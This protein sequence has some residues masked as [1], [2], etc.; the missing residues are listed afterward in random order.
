M[1]NGV[2]D[3]VRVSSDMKDSKLVENPGDAIGTVKTGGNASVVD[4]GVPEGIGLPER[5]EW[6]EPL[7]GESKSSRD[8]LL[9]NMSCSDGRMPLRLIPLI[10]DGDAGGLLS[11]YDRTEFGVDTWLEDELGLL[12]MPKIERRREGSETTFSELLDSGVRG[13]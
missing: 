4:C 2:G 5:F 12:L 11:S 7:L 13:V 8:R 1:V 3:G 9:L 6:G 10:D